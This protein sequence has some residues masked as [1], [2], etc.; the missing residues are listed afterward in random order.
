MLSIPRR[1]PCFRGSSLEATHFL[2][3]I[4]NRAACTTG[5]ACSSGT[6]VGATLN[7]DDSNVCT[8]DAC[9]PATGCVHTNNNA[10]C[11]T[12]G[13][14]CTD[15]VCA[16]GSCTHPNDNTNACTDGNACTGDACVSGSCQSWYAPT[17]GCCASSGNCNDGNA[18]T[19]DTC[20]G[21]PGGSCTN[22]VPGGCS[23]SA[24]CNDANGCTTDTCVGAVGGSAL[25]YDGSN[26]YV[27]MG[28]ASGESAL[29]ARAFTLEAWVKRDGSTWGV[30]TSTGTGGVT[31]V[32]V[33]AKGRAE[34]E[35]AGLNCNYFLGLI[36]DSVT[37]TTARLGAD[38][39]QLAAA[40]GWAVGRRLSERGTGLA[41]RAPP[42]VARP[43][44]M[45]GR[46]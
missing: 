26:D 4:V 45:Q 41:Q 19:T 13:N 32:P 29:G 18:G 10:T 39:E 30:T 6:C 37:P 21:A 23:T 2:V 46:S 8:N 5:D 9:S 28:A 31:A 20:I 27:T 14:P 43:T 42:R 24:Q 36:P 44:P 1:S 3:S 35:T 12:D 7:C 15:D 34:S 33:I 11:A 16:A 17:A 40:G 25:N 22:V 38:F